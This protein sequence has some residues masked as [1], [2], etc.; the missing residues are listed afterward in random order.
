MSPQIMAW[1]FESMVLFIQISVAVVWLFGLLLVLAPKLALSLQQR[2]NFRFSSRQLSRPL[3]V[4]VNIDRYFYRHARPVGVVLMLGAI[5]M[6]VLNWQLP[7]QVQVNSPALWAWLADALYWFLWLSGIVI[8]FIG[9]ACFFRPSLLK[10]LENKANLWVSTRQK[11]Q[12]L[13]REYTPLDSLL[14]QN[15]RLVGIVIAAIC[16]LLLLIL[17]RA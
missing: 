5:G 13:S 4:P 7:G 15:P 6:L 3:E 1:L 12:F 9:L 17:I 11:G 2:L 10:P 8:F 14:E 16:S